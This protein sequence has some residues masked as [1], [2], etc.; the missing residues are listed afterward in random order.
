[1]T[2][3]HC[4]T[5]GGTSLGFTQLF[6]DL[7]EILEEVHEAGRVAFVGFKGGDIFPAN[8]TAAVA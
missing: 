7:I 4:L 6:F 2:R 1:M 3:S 5:Q 8:V